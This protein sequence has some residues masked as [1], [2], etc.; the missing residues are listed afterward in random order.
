MRY[1]AGHY[2]T[3]RRLLPDFIDDDVTEENPVRCIEAYVER[4]D[5]ERLGVARA[6]PALT[7]RPAYNPR[8]LFKLY[9]SG[10]LNRIRSS[11]RLEW[12]RADPRPN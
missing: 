1:I 5:L 10:Y 9:I 6:Q 2:R 7:G 3:Q 12:Y 11:R 8:D 4:L